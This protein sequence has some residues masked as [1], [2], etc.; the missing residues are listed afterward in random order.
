M[1]FHRIAVLVASFTF[2]ALVV[3]QSTDAS[4]YTNKQGIEV[5]QN[6]PAPPAAA[7]TTT[8][9]TPDQAPAQHTSSASK[10]S[11]VPA[12]KSESPVKDARFQ[13]PPEAQKAADDGRL[14][15]LQQELE[16]E[17]KD[18]QSKSKILSDKHMRAGLDEPQL[19]RLKDT[20]RVHERNILD[21]NSEINR[22]LGK[23]RRR[24]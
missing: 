22:L 8:P 16:Q 19:T 4:R 3:A 9:S 7:S 5:I 14:E 24:Q 13:I 10:A 6:R 2:P 15:I 11:V 21:L 18:A 17:L 12:E 1:C 20:L 23:N